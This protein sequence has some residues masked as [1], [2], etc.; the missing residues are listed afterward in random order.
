M[1]QIFSF[2]SVSV[3]VL[4][5]QSVSTWASVSREKIFCTRIFIRESRITPAARETEIRST[6]PLGSIPRRAA[7]EDTTASSTGVCRH[8]SASRNKK[9]PR[10]MMHTLVK[11]VTLRMEPRSSDSTRFSFRTS[12]T[13]FAA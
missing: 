6:R 4:S 12:E 3:P 9:A 7:A 10:G 1:E 8:S 2:P 5:R 13:S 11:F